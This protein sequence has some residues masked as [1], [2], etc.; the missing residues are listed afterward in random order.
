MHRAYLRCQANTARQ[1]KVQPTGKRQVRRCG[2]SL[3]SKDTP[4]ISHTSIK[5]D[6][7]N[8]TRVNDQRGAQVLPNWHI[9]TP[10]VSRCNLMEFNLFG[11]TI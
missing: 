5:A 2:A 3:D 1:T 8:S 6:I 9:S 11:D 7:Q 4:L 10:L